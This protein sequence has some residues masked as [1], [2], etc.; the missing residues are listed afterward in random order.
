MKLLHTLSIDENHFVLVFDNNSPSNYCRFISVVPKSNKK[1]YLTG[2]TMKPTSKKEYK[3]K[4]LEA[5]KMYQ[6][7]MS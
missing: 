1:D 2:H 5:L 6:K 7:Q 4:G 3:E